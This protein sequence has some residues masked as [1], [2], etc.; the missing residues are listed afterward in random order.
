MKTAQEAG[1]LYVEKGILMISYEL[2]DDE[3][4]KILKML[5]DPMKWD[6]VTSEF[7]GESGVEME[8]GFVSSVELNHWKEFWLDE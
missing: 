4:V 8:L 3:E 6:E 7:G 1:I 2:L 5:I